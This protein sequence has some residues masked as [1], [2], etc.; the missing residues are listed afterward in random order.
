MKKHLICMIMISFVFTSCVSSNLCRFHLVNSPGSP[1]PNCVDIGGEEWVLKTDDEVFD[2]EKRMF[3]YEHPVYLFSINYSPTW[4]KEE[5]AEAQQFTARFFP[6][7]TRRSSYSK[8]GELSAREVHIR[9]A[10]LGQGETLTDFS[11]RVLKG[12]AL[13]SSNFNILSKSPVTID[14]R[15]AEQ[16]Y[17]TA[18]FDL[19]RQKTDFKLWYVFTIVKGYGYIFGF[20]DEVNE[21][22][23][24]LR[25]ARKMFESLSFSEAQGGKT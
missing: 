16:M 14:G 9:I 6:S 23:S 1:H 19:G 11:N 7:S 25:D 22:D 10:P 12:S 15:S 24:S 2:D 21:F 8:R 17:A 3:V 4:V 13:E 5:I 20:R 18:Q